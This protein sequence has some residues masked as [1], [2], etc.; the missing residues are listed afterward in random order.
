M[1]NKLLENNELLKATHDSAD[2]PLKI[3]NIDIPCYVLE[4]GT[5]VISLRGL[6]TAFT[7]KYGGGVGVQKMPRFLAIKGVNSLISTDLMARIMNPIEFKPKTGRSAFG[8]E[9]TLLPEI[10]EVLLDANKAGVLGDSVQADIAETLIRGFARVGIIALI[11]E[12]TDYQYDREKDE[13]Q[14]ILKAYISEA[15]LPWQK[16]FPDTFYRELFRLNGWDFDVKG[17]KKRPGV[18]G[19]WTNKLVY[20]QL[21]PG[22]LD[23]LKKNTPKSPSGNR[24]HRYHQLLTE[25]IGNSHLSGQIN[26]IITLFQLSDNMQH[27]WAQFEKLQWRQLGQIELPFSFDGKGHTIEPIEVENLSDFDKNLKKALDYKE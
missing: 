27:M 4:N 21:P 22:V 20:D 18:V 9:A 15:L 25:D 3:G 5:R 19:T 24:Q 13:L 17:I 23:E 6:N 26:Q 16:R 7:G 2:N 11:D 1:D 8:Y 14:K 12:A 10:C